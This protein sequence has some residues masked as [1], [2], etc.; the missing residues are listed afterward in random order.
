MPHA[1]LNKEMFFHYYLLNVENHQLRV[2]SLQHVLDSAIVSYL[3][4][5]HHHISLGHVKHKRW[6]HTFLI[7][8]ML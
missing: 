5:R 7:V 2:S 8:H 3:I 4:Q 1:F 6:F